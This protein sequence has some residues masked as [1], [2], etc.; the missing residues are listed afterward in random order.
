MANINPTLSSSHPQSL[1]NVNG[2][3]FFVA[4]DGAS[5]YELWKTIRLGAVKL[6][7]TGEVLGV[8]PGTVG[9]HLRRGLSAL[10]L[11]LH[12]P[13]ESSTNTT[14]QEVLQ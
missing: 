11:A 10:R 1:T 2:T 4:N 5:G 8:D 7:Q 14:T 6:E 13:V 9:T 3:L 12:G